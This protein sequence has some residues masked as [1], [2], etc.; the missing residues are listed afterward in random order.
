MIVVFTDESGDDIDQME[1]TTD[2]CRRLAMPVYVLGR[3]APFGRRA[4]H[5]KWIDTDPNFDQRPQ[6]VPVN[7]GPETLMPERLKLH[8]AGSD[9]PLLDSGYG[10][11][12][13]TRL[14]YETGGLYF[15]GHPNRVVGR[16]VSGFETR[17]LAAHFSAF[18]DADVMRRY[19]PDYVPMQEY[20]NQINSNRARRASSMSPKTRS[21]WSGARVGGERVTVAPR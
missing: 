5:V 8:F 1:S 7:L 2:L 20:M 3:P 9:D 10:P 11:F 12:G 21:A 13:L 16:R 19:R 17:N 15:A 4:A 14:C 6:W 18:F